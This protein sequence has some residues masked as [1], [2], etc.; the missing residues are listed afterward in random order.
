M[1]KRPGGRGGLGREMLGEEKDRRWWVCDLKKFFF[2]WLFWFDVGKE[3]GL[4]F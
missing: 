3:M 2:F 4:S 1:E